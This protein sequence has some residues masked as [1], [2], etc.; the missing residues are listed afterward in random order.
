MPA[1]IVIPFNFNPVTTTVKT[2]SYT[3]PAGKYAKVTPVGAKML[4]DGVS[5][6]P[7][8]TISMTGTAVAIGATTS[9]SM[10]LNMKN[11]FLESLSITQTRSGT[12]ASS[13]ATFA[14][15]DFGT[16][17]LIYSVTKTYALNTLN[18]TPL[19][20]CVSDSSTVA[21]NVTAAGS[22]TSGT[23]TSSC[24]ATFYVKNDTGFIWVPS[25]AVLNGNNYI[26]EEYNQIS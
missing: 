5:I 20:Q 9:D 10:V 26:V 22:G 4:I 1:P 24:N 25:G 18:Y 21:L 13:N 8:V 19:V 16:R 14:F 23:V 12:A 3:I 7:S 2:G 17:E 15:Y 6:Y 11:M